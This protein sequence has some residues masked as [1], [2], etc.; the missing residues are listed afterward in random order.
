MSAKT[1]RRQIPR[2]TPTTVPRRGN[3]GQADVGAGN[4][5]KTGLSPTASKP[6]HSTVDAALKWVEDNAGAIARSLFQTG[7]NAIEALI[8]MVGALASF[9][10][11]AFLTA[12][13]FFFVSTGF[14]NV[15]DFLENL[16]P[17]ANRERALELIS[18]LDR[19]VSGFVRGR[20]II[21]LILGAF[22][23]LGWW[24]AGVP[25][26]LAVGMATGLL[27]VFPYA[28][29][30]GLPVAI[31]LLAL[32]NHA[33]FRG[34]WWW[35]VLAPAAIYQVGQ[36]AD[37]YLLTPSIQGKE[38]DLDIPSI[39]FA[40]FAGGAL[41]GIYGLLIAIPFAACL[42]ILIREIIWPRYRAWVRGE[43]KD[44]LPLD[45]D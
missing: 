3:R 39:M 16:V 13:F 4:G 26:A 42:K 27:G 31:V 33:G 18:K 28:A 45:P 15:T 37:D 23:S 35:V 6:E 19:V 29:L 30:A 7:G 5:G 22:F 34:T 41:F 17:E 43:R 1:R 25:L 21:G 12:F 2:A 8:G 9:G 10:L 32:E 14:P 36:L 40:V 24:L 44:L 11:M 20:L 38:T